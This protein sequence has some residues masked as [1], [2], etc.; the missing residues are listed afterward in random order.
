MITGVIANLNILT[1]P[2]I[3]KNP[4]GNEVTI[5]KNATGVLIT[6]TPIIGY[7]STNS[8]SANSALITTL[9]NLGLNLSFNVSNITITG[10]NLSLSVLTAYS[11]VIKNVSNVTIATEPIS[12]EILNPDFVSTQES[13]K[14]CLLFDPTESSTT[15][16]NPS[17]S[18]R[19]LME[20]T[21]IPV[22]GAEELKASGAYNTTVESCWCGAAANLSMRSVL[23][24]RQI[25]NCKGTSPIVFQAVQTGIL[26]TITEYVPSMTISADFAC[27]VV[28]DKSFSIIPISFTPNN[29]A[30]HNTCGYSVLRYSLKDQNGNK[31]ILSQTKTGTVTVSNTSTTIAGSS[32]LFLTELKVGDSIYNV[33]NVLVG[34]VFSITS[35][36]VLNLEQNANFTGTISFNSTS[37]S[38][39]N[40]TTSN[41]FSYVPAN[42]GTYTVDVTFTNCCDVFTKIYSINVCNSYLLE[43]GTCN[44]PNIKNIS[45]V[46]YVKINLTTYDELVLVDSV[47]QK[48][49]FVDQLVAPN[50]QLNLGNLIDGFYLLTIQDVSNLGVNLGIPKTQVLFY[51]CNIKAC[52]VALIQKV[53]CFDF[54]CNNEYDYSKIITEKLKFDI[55]KSEI[56]SYWNN[57]KYQQSLPDSW[58]V[59]S[60]LQELSTYTDALAKIQEIC[61]TCGLL[62]NND[63][64]KGMIR[65]VK[66]NNCTTCNQ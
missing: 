55:Y 31:V 22:L 62:D 41:T 39:I 35:N 21:F 47:T 2:Q 46:N 24:I 52:E 43:T 18:N 13:C 3:F 4:V 42:L 57:I 40:P 34:K 28:K 1:N 56:Y 36:T 26:V 33:S 51:D 63:C 61:T 32:T 5:A 49:L 27:C 37:Y 45:N 53:L 48:S 60:H 14:Y 17:I 6:I 59:E 19:G 64:F 7:D 65:T 58:D 23:T 15:S 11:A 29:S 16:N 30:P 9:N 38:F 66:S 50:S 20:Y 8:V 25:P 10:S 54:N 44:N 12:I